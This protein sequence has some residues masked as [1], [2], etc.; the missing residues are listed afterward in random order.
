[1]A[2]PEYVPVIA[3][4]RLRVDERLPTPTAW[5]ADRVAEL[6]QQGAQPRGPGMGTAGP[7]Q[8]YALK[9]ARHLS[10]QVVL[11]PHEH[12]E[13]ALA[14]CLG[15]ALRR[16]ALFG[17]GPVIHDLELAFGLWGYLDGA[18]E[19]LVSFRRPLFAGAA[20]HYAV[21]RAI[22]DLVPDSTLRLTPDEVRGR[23]DGGWR[24]L[25]EGG[26]ASPAV[27]EPVA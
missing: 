6:K 15:V 2:Q 7:D 5:W 20:H 4:D 10:G 18:P 19:D 3:R 8:G 11:A 9:L 26:P 1:M 21:Q 24:E 23:S 16:A 12:R 22:A 17:R 14:G 13:D 27:A 25:L